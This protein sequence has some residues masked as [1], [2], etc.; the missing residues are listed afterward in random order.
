MTKNEENKENEKNEEVKMF[1]GVIYYKKNKLDEIWSYTAITISIISAIYMYFVYC[2]YN[3]CQIPCFKNTS[4]FYCDNSSDWYYLITTPITMMNIIMPI[5][6]F[7]SYGFALYSLLM[8]P[9][10]IMDCCSKTLD[11]IKF[12]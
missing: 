5:L 9:F 11:K 7:M 1:C 3:I 10:L 2:I 6:M 8:S 12:I 4:P